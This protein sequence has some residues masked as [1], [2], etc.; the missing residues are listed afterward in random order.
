MNSDARAGA[1]VVTFHPSIRDFENFQRVRL[2]VDLVIIVD[3]G[4]DE[5][6]LAQLRRICREPGFVLIENG[7]NLGVAMALNIGVREV[8]RERCHWI[9][10]FDQD[11]TVTDGFIATLVEEYTAFGREH[12]IMQI[13]PRYRD[14]NTGLEGAVSRFRDGGAFLTITSGSLFSRQAFEAC[15]FFQ[16]NLFV[17]GVDDDYSLRIRAKGYYIGVSQKAV[18][19]HQSGHPTYMNVL[20]R[21]FATKN[22]R[23]ESRYYSARNKVWILRTYGGRFPQLIIPTLRQFLTIPLKIA[24][25]EQAPVT[26]IAMFF[27]GLLDGLRGQMG[28]LPS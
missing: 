11:S 28:K 18:L 25:M 1:V 24:L 27:R 6:A 9:A 4:S 17:Y 5:C 23:P 2:Q 13:I 7:E 22:Y 8:L 3:N 15:G 14:P 12:P 26:K 19:L 20:G 21:R 16:E 10:L